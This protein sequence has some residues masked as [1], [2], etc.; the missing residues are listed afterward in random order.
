MRKLFSLWT[1]VV[2]LLSFVGCS[3]DTPE[4][5]PVKPGNKPEITLTEGELT[6]NSY[7]FEVSTTVAGELGY[8]VVADGFS[9]PT[10]NEIFTHHSIDIT[11]KATIT[12]DNLNDNT[13]YT[14]I[15]ILRAAEGGSLSDPKK[16]TFTTPDDGVDSPITINNIGYNN[17]SFR[18]E[19]SG[20]IVF[21]CIDKASLEYY[22]QT[23]QDYISTPGIA[24]IT[25]G[26]IDVDWVDGGSYGPYQMRMR[27]D[28]DYYVIA[29]RSDSQG[30]ITGEI[31]IKE[32]RTLRRPT[33]EAGITTNLTEIGSTEVTIMTQ[34]DDTVEEYYVLVRDKVWSDGIIAGYGESMLC[35]LVK[36][37]SAGSWHLYDDN[38]A[39]WSGLAAETTYYCHILVIDNK[40]AEALT[41]IEFTTTGKQHNAPEVEFFITADP[42]NPHNTQYLNIRADM[43]ASVK[44][45]FRP[46]ADVQVKRISEEMSDEQIVE[47]YGTEISQIDLDAITNAGLAI[48]MEDLWPEVEYTAMAI[49][50]NAEQTATFKATTCTTS[51]QAAA[52]RVESELFTSLLGEWELTYTLRQENFMEFTVTET[53]TIAQGVD[54]KTKADYRDQNRLVILGFPFNVSTTG[55]NQQIPVYTPEDLLKALPKYYSYG[56]NLIYRDYG[57]KIFIEIGEGDTLS[58]PTSKGTYLYN[59]DTIG[60]LNFYGCDYDPNRDENYTAPAPFPMTISEDGN[61]LTIGAYH[62]GEEFGFGI[63]YPAVFLNDYQFKAVA[64]SDIVLKRVK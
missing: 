40:G 14:L 34:P 21:Q 52:P 3:P 31:Y 26:P 41:R 5:N 17:A 1:L 28:S 19:L 8:A 10:I 55:V 36:S 13:K 64:T 46:T 24:I 63:Y 33:S 57:P 62:S 30:N 16:L 59:W 53:V 42:E 45:V 32:F 25:T 38:L 23:P 18:I 48:K 11:D 7:T 49:V 39:T 50:K 56:H 35:T 15:A 37:P 44:V 12:I 58:V 6:A 2:A 54:E 61:T 60:Y 47:N 51:K 27:E 20:T 29:A 4:P 22:N 9:T 43:A